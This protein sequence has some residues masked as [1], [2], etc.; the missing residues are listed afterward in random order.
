VTGEI[1]TAATG[2]GVRIEVDGP[3]LE[4]YLISRAP[5]VIIQGPIGSGKSR[6]SIYKLLL[7][8][9]RQ[10]P[11]PGEKIARRR[12]YVVRNTFD[13]LDRTVVKD[14]VEQFPEDRW[15]KMVGQKPKT[16]YIRNEMLDWEV[17]FLALDD[18]ADVKKLLSSQV[19]DF[20]IN[21]GVQVPRNIVVEAKSRVDRYPNAKGD[22]YRPQVII[23]TN[24]GPEDHWLTI[25]SG[26][27]PIPEGVDDET[28]R[29]LTKPDDWEIL[30]QPP[31]MFEV[32]DERGKVVGYRINPARENARNAGE[33]YYL[34]QISGASNRQIAVK[35]LNRP[36]MMMD[37]RAVWPEFAD[38]LHMASHPLVAM[39]G[40]PIMVGLDFGRTPAAVMGQLVRGRWRILRELVTENM[41]AKEFARLLKGVLAQHYPEHDLALWGDPTGEDFGQ[42]DSE[43]TPFLMFQAEGLRVL[44][45]PTNDTSL[46]QNAVREVLLT[47]IDGGPR[48]EV[49]ARCITLKGALAGGY[50]LQRVRGHGADRYSDTPVK[51][52]YSHV[53][54]AL[55][56]LVMGGG[57]GAA[58]LGRVKPGAGRMTGQ[59]RAITGARVRGVRR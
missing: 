4:R 34:N 43:R 14:W 45:A 3:C 12:T 23:D 26:Q 19:S 42:N 1:E 32:R 44:P 41:G 39:P 29:M 24:P 31:A 56:Y 47:M 50:Q 15:G 18:D 17:T 57:E 11:V 10:K 53:A 49:D 8:A 54:D 27:R 46:R 48:M 55:Q 7:N 36:A 21:E 6:A 51:N 30:I 59:A 16:Q 58:L 25:M 22:C 13:E 38:D 5:V 28:R 20:W 40:H 37:G 35:V 9:L 33:R 2:F 52:R